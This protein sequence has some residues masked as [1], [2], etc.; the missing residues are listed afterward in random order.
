[1]SVNVPAVTRPRSRID[2][3]P[4]H[5]RGAPKKFTGRSHE[6][7]K[8]I[9]HC[10]KLFT[11]NN[12]FTDIEKV[13][14]MSEYCS[15]N[16][17]HILEGMKHYSTPNWSL[18]CSHMANMF[19]ADK[20]LQRHR[21][22][23]L[24]KLTDK[25]QKIP[26]KTMSVWRKYLRQF[27]MIAGWLVHQGLIDDTESARYLWHGINSRPRHILENRL[28]AK[29]PKRDMTIP[30]TEDEIIGVGDAKFKRG[31]FDADIYSEDSDDSDDSELE[32]DSDSSD[33]EY[34]DSDEEIEHKKKKKSKKSKP[35]AIIK[36]KAKRTRDLSGVVVRPTASTAVASDTSTE[37][38]DLV[39]RLSNMS[40]DD[41][42]Y[43]YLYYK[44]TSLDPL[45]ARCVRAPNLAVNAPPLPPLPPNN[46]RNNNYVAPANQFG[47][48]PNANHPPLQPADR[49]CWGCGDKGHGLWE[50]PIMAEPI[51]NGD[52]KRGDRGIEWKD[53]SLLRR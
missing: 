47:P 26:I 50:C 33:S 23:D 34:S 38:G 13:E 40:L 9:A 20:D 37:V 18:L 30:F 36:K 12:V 21:P 39:K 45:V 7:T 53:G 2:M 31:R 42:E 10:D 52:L 22:A 19:D 24:R 43:N 32:S 3:P 16:V 35:K 17:L 25:W 27:T 1:M 6:V 41:K 14:C 46:F 28:L 4:L 8:F 49:T 51:R 48:N 29:D 15:R 11:Q 5:T 44:A